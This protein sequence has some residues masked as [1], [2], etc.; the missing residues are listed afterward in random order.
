MRLINLQLKN[1]KSI[2]ELELEFKNGFTVITGPNGIGKSNVTDAIL[3]VLGEKS[4]KRLRVNS[5]IELINKTT[6]AK[7]TYVRASFE[8]E[9]DN[10]VI[11]R[12][13]D[14]NDSWIKLNGA[15]VR[16]RDIARIFADS[17]IASGGYA[18]LNHQQLMNIFFD[19]TVLTDVIKEVAGV[20]KIYIRREEVLGRLGELEEK[21]DKLYILLEEKKAV[22]EQYFKEAA[23]LRLYNYLMRLKEALINL[24]KKEKKEKLM[25]ELRRQLENKKEIEGKLN[26][27]K[28]KIVDI[29]KYL[30]EVKKKRDFLEKKSSELLEEF[31]EKKEK[32]T[33]SKSKLLFINS[34]ISQLNNTIQELELKKTQLN[35]KKNKLDLQLNDIENEINSLEEKIEELEIKRKS[36]EQFNDILKL[37]DLKNKLSTI[38]LNLLNKE[39]MKLDLEKEISNLSKDLIKV[40]NNLEEILKEKSNLE[41]RLEKLEKDYVEAKRLLEEWEKEQL[42]KRERE[43]EITEHLY[44][45]ENRIFEV[46]LAIKNIENNLEQLETNLEDEVI[47]LLSGFDGFI[48]KIANLFEFDEL[49]LKAF[50][51]ILGN[52]ANYYLVETLDDAIKF[53]KLLKKN[54]VYGVTFIVKEKIEPI[55]LR[56]NFSYPGAILAF[57]CIKTDYEDVFKF[58]LKDW[59]IV[60]NID[61]ANEF[62]RNYSNYAVATLEGE[63]LR[64]SLVSVPKKGNTF[65]VFSRNKEIEE[66]KNSLEDYKGILKKLEDKKIL[67]LKEKEQLSK[68]SGNDYVEATSKYF[69]VEKK[70]QEIKKELS[71][72]DFEEEISRNTIKRQEEELE[73][74]KNQLSNLKKEIEKL[75]TEKQKIEEQLEFLRETDIEVNIDNIK[76]KLNSLVLEEE[77]IKEKLTYLRDK[78][79]DLQY[80]LLEVEEELKKLEE[81]KANLNN[82]LVKLQDEKKSLEEVLG[83]LKELSYY[84]EEREKIYEEQKRLIDVYQSKQEELVKSMNN[85]NELKY[86]IQSVED[87]I[88]RLEKLINEIEYDETDIVL[89]LDLKVNMEQLENSIQKLGEINFLAMKNYKSIS[90]EYKTLKKE[91]KDTVSSIEK[92]KDLLKDLEDEIKDNIKIAVRQI[93]KSFKKTIKM[94]F[95][96][97][98]EIKLV[99]NEEQVFIKIKD[100]NVKGY[101]TFHSFSSGEKN[102]I[103]ISFLYSLYK[104]KKPPVIVLDEIDVNLDEKNCRLFSKLLKELSDNSQ[105]IAITHNKDVMLY[106]DEILGITKVQG[107]VRLLN[108]NLTTLALNIK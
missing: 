10:Y 60:D 39:N 70:I 7:K 51:Q 44:E 102:A 79:S 42:K 105:V 54:N 28:G 78:K 84:E 35:A 17:G 22:Y 66:L 85:Y 24:E 12:Y 67:L 76:E 63:T 19:R 104:V 8:D 53:V 95:Y 96:D 83:D 59:V 108:L 57:D 41:E 72:L 5:M 32:I 62:L 50:S 23:K 40:K 31:L 100:K 26:E 21:L 14:L 30:E 97:R 56:R 4:P 86:K 75:T 103:G 1:F 49:Y 94:F 81:K 91:L 55:F 89:V 27:L 74:K 64:K 65:S 13:Q 2:D 20:K 9:N 90:K 15:K 34:E 3:W 71:K 87:E 101:T 80:L 73:L 106:A 29:E 37:E 18:I 11:E 92:L 68:G 47:K 93:N 6:S 48:G 45:V 58:L 36:F 46:R 77:K 82:R 25:R 98:L 61:E 43:K 99:A 33:E 16:I 107:K 38:N 88:S 69:E 52:R